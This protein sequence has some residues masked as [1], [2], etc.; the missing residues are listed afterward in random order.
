MLGGLY[1]K[2]GEG[3]G[4]WGKREKEGL[5]VMIYGWVG[6]WMDGIHTITYPSINIY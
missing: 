6:G 5:K 4:K 1:E 3:R 2:R